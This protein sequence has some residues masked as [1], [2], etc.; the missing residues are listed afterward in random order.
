[1]EF[2]YNMVN[3]F[4]FGDYWDHEIIRYAYFF[5]MSLVIIF[6]ENTYYEELSIG[7]HI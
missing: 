5:F 7:A 1:M 6:W 3:N 4:L 2:L